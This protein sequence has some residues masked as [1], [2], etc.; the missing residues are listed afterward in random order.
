MSLKPKQ[1]GQSTEPLGYDVSDSEMT[2]SMSKKN[3]S[4]LITMQIKF[5]N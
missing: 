2:A 1:S 3:D 4:E 5:P